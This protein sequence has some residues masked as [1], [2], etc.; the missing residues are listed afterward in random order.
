MEGWFLAKLHVPLMD[1]FL[2]VPYLELCATDVKGRNNRR[3]DKHDAVMRHE[4][5]PLDLVAMEAK[6]HMQEGP[7]LSD[8]EK[9]ARSMAG[10]LQRAKEL[11]PSSIRE[12]KQDMLRS[13]G[14]LSSGKSSILFFGIY[15][16]DIDLQTFTIFFF[17]SLCFS[18]C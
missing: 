1:I 16:V 17:S 7:M 9:V 8:S 11:L 3:G 18:Q 13:F 6:H 10:N 2:A 4:V 5:Y 12:Q 15:T 14:I